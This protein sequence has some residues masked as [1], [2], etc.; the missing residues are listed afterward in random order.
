MG[1]RQSI[2]PSP[3]P[4][5]RRPSCAAY[6]RPHPLHMI[7]EHEI[8]RARAIVTRMASQQLGPEVKVR[9]KS[10]SLHEPPKALL[11]PFLDAEAAGKPFA[12]RPFVPRCIAIVWSTDNERH[13]AESIISLDTGTEVVRDEA[14]HGQHGFIDW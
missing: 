9:F 4:A 13:V 11:L 1:I 3:A 7:T 5:E 10:I 2:I 8:M 12:D 6:I 14:A